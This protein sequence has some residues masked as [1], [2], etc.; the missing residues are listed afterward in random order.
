MTGPITVE[1]ARGSRGVDPGDFPLSIGG[2]DA[3][4]RLHGVP[5]LE[6]VGWL[7]IADG[8]LFIQAGRTGERIVCNGDPVATSQWLR[9]GDVVRIGATRIRIEAAAGGLHLSIERFE[10]RD[11]AGAPVVVPKTVAPARPGG[12]PEVIRPIEF[13]PRL[14]HGA[15]RRPLR[16]RWKAVVAAAAV[17]IASGA[18]W[19]LFTAR[20]VRIEI[21]PEP[22]RMDLATG[23]SGIHLGN[24]YLIRPGRYE[25]TAAREGYR[26][27]QVPVEVTGDR[28][29]SFRFTLERLPGLLVI[30]TGGV[31]GAEVSIDGEVVGITPLDPVELA[32]GEHDVRIV[33]E[34]FLEF[35][36]RVNIAGGGET[37]TLRADLA[38]GWATVTFLSSPPGAA[39][40]IAGRTVGATP[41]TAEVAAGTHRLEYRLDRFRTHR[42]SLTVEAGIE[43]VLPAVTMIPA[44]G[45]LA[46]NSDP[47][48]AAVTVNDEYRGQTPVEIAVPPGRVHVVEL[49][50][51]GHQAAERRVQLEPGEERELTV[52]LAVIE[53]EIEIRAAPADAEVWI[54]G[55]SKGRADGVFRLPAIPQEI[56]IR[57][58]GFE[59]HRV[60]VTPRPGI[61]QSIRV[62]LQAVQE[63]EA[64]ATA[65]AVQTSQR[66]DLV[67]IEG[68]RFRMGAPR[69]EPGRR[70]NE[71]EREV[72]LTRP[73][74][75]AVREVSNAEFRR[76]D[77]KHDSG[78]AGG[79]SLDIDDH[80]VVRVR[81]EDA[82]QYCNWLSA[83]EGLPRAYHRVEDRMVPVKPMT[84]GYRLPTEAEWA[85]A[86]R[87]AAAAGPLKYPW[88]ESMPVPPGA[89]NYA[90]LSARGLLS[91]NLTGYDDTFPA[92]AP[93]DSFPPNAFGL[94]NMGGNVAEWVHDLYNI[95]PPGDDRVERDPLGPEEG[96]LHVIRGSSWMDSS[97]SELRLTFRDYGR[98]ARPDVGFRIARYAE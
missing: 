74:Y 51:A 31:A 85:F 53:G 8:D 17:L 54:G 94:Y 95:Y 39:V 71:T 50:R 9:S 58:D 96:E 70:A 91:A 36:E 61:P 14:T 22:E 47:S 26:R 76:F 48:G 79:Y 45:T 33:A 32:A 19:F 18:A 3:D 98:K 77:P 89:G 16:I 69:R 46:V 2:P 10:E 63:A 6:P 11:L 80:P 40:A 65:A 5:G 49:T 73:F 15:R 34:R 88:G 28:T 1:D 83:R 92:T 97:V 44:D 90:D 56:E 23:L 62:R 59:T 67:L 68:G 52:E 86:A 43:Q 42:D 30:D 25:L 13:R 38:P 37:R 84:T 27:L 75:I 35:A 4:I 24:R 60:T 78:L 81:W 72:E 64:E 57:K 20:A 82:A 41:V 7:G 29:Q 55:Q 87:T 12:A 21:D 93:V 66:Q